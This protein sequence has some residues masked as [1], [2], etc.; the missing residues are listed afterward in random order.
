MSATP[1]TGEIEVVPGRLPS[2]RAEA[3]LRFLTE[4]A[5]FS[6][7]DAADELDRAICLA[8]ARTGELA[9]VA[10]AGPATL[11]LVGGVDVWLQRSVTAPEAEDALVNACFDALEEAYRPEGEG[12]IGLC[13]VIRGRDRMSR[14]AVCPRTGTSESS[15]IS[16]RAAVW[17]PAESCDA[18]LR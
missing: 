7:D 5:G 12:P 3:V 15:F 8:V 14:D 4:G 2:E 10:S 16:A 1:F 13:Q 6:D 18:N 11:P 9:G 17:R